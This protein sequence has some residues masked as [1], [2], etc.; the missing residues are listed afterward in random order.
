MSDGVQH[1]KGGVFYT[2][3]RYTKVVWNDYTREE[4]KC[5]RSLRSEVTFLQET[6]QLLQTPE[7]NAQHLAAISLMEHPP[8][9]G[10][11]HL[12]NLAVGTTIVVIAIRMHSPYKMVFTWID[13]GGKEHYHEMEVPHTASIYTL[14]GEALSEIYHY[15][16]TEKAKLTLRLGFVAEDEEP[17]GKDVQDLTEDTAN[18]NDTASSSSSSISDYPEDTAS[19]SETISTSSSS[20]YDYPEDHSS[21]SSSSS[22]STTS[23]S[24]SSSSSSSRGGSSS[25]SQADSGSNSNSVAAKKTTSSSSTRNSG[26]NNSNTDTSPNRRSKRVQ[27]T[28]SGPASKL[29][30]GQTTRPSNPPFDEDYAEL[31]KK[32]CIQ[33]SE[34]ASRGYVA[35]ETVQEYT[36]ESFEG[37]E[38]FAVLEDDLRKHLLSERHILTRTE[39]NKVAKQMANHEPEYWGKGFLEDVKDNPRRLNGFYVDVKE[40]IPVK[41]DKN[42]LNIVSNNPREGPGDGAL[43][44][45]KGDLVLLPLAIGRQRA[46]A[47]KATNE[48]FVEFANILVNW[49]HTPHLRKTM[50]KL[51]VNLKNLTAPFPKYHGM[52]EEAAARQGKRELPEIPLAPEYL[53][54]A[55]QRVMAAYAPLMGVNLPINEKKLEKMMKQMTHMTVCWYD[56]NV[57]A[58]LDEVHYDGPRPHIGNYVTNGY[59]VMAFTSAVVETALARLVFIGPGDYISFT[60]ALRYTASHAVYQVMPGDDPAKWPKGLSTD[61]IADARSIFNFRTGT[62]KEEDVQSFYAVE[63]ASGVDLKLLPEKY[64]TAPAPAKPMKGT[65]V[66]AGATKPTKPTTGGGVKT[67]AAKPVAQQGTSDTAMLGGRLFQPAKVP[68]PRV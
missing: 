10:A 2:D 24:N 16:I 19:T 64:R 6:N 57:M 50:K 34:D 49:S 40:G 20:K 8:G 55:S 32:W 63:R 33:Y 37:P 41:F 36:H 38:P 30:F 27:A 35:W 46:A 65:A 39:A 3:K 48:A 51:F 31:R 22:K 61:N 9:S 58:H 26:S 5:L 17:P 45:K 21:T 56:K 52:L 28:P 12:E 14:G 42:G 60:G 11:D 67:R 43:G 25:S 68:P 7:V 4:A 62:D 59:G 47:H 54:E 23:S 44:I 66:P 13:K 1:K 18:T 53:L 15:H 29:P